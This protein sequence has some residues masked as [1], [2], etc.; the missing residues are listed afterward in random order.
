M[1]TWGTVACTQQTRMDPGDLERCQLTYEVAYD[2]SWQAMYNFQEA[3]MPWISAE[4]YEARYGESLLPD[5]P[6]KIDKSD[7]P[8]DFPK[9]VLV[10]SKTPDQFSDQYKHLAD[11]I[12]RLN[13]VRQ[14]LLGSCFEIQNPC[15]SQPEDMFEGSLESLEE[16]DRVQKRR[17]QIETSGSTVEEMLSELEQCAQRLK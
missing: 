13:D 4:E 14:I 5:Y 3:H 15:S 2:M 6:N 10:R 17:H 1:M 12:E 9:N 16:R 7:F 8:S 11:N